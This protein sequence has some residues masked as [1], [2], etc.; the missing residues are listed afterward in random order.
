MTLNTHHVTISIDEL[1]GQFRLTIAIGEL[2][3]VRFYNSMKKALKNKKC[4]EGALKMMGTVT[5]VHRG[6]RA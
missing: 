3:E 5:A 4:I 1:D 6:G 2:K